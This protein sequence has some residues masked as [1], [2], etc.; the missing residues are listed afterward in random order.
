MEL[1]LDPGVVIGIAAAE[2]LYVR[3][4]RILRGRGVRVPVRQV[5]AWH[6]AIALWIVGLVSPIDA[7]GSDLLWAHMVQ[8][9]LIA[10][11]AAPLMLMGIRNPVLAF[12][13]PRPAL[14]TFARTRWLRGLWRWLRRPLVAVPVYVVVLYGWHIGGAFEAAVRHPM[15][16]AL[17]HAS[18][19]AI[20]VLVWW[21]ALEPKRRR[22]PGQLWKVPYMLGARFAGMFLGMAFLFIRVPIYEDV[23]GSGVRGQGLTAVHD[24]QLA[25]GLMVTTDIVLMVAAL[26]FFFA[27]AA[28]DADR[29]DRATDAA[30]L[31]S[32]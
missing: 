17:Q 14:V 16:H 4:L 10:D 18:F 7:W 1:S 28:S 11:L 20:G 21:S 22:L 30:L 23:Y 3:A 19:I 2:Y 26:C 27:R 25:G 5:V 15:V 6:G 9:L 12:F 29:Q 13:L 31:T 24:Q 32:R 8:H